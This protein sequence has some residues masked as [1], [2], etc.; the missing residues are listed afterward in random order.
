MKKKKK[1]RN[2]GEERKEK[3]KRGSNQLRV[4]MITHS[5]THSETV[6]MTVVPV[7]L[8]SNYSQSIKK[9]WRTRQRRDSIFSACAAVT[10]LQKCES[11]LNR[12]QISV[13]PDTLGSSGPTSQEQVKSSPVL[14]SWAANLSSLFCQIL[15]TSSKSWLSSFPPCGSRRLHRLQTLVLTGDTAL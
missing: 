3:E 13:M 15:P 12:D 9:T 4:T 7:L 14:G 11:Q 2:T 8:W 10:L 1:G 5:L 6:T